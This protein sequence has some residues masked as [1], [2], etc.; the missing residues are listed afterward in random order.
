MEGLDSA[1]SRQK[2]TTESLNRAVEQFRVVAVAY[3]SGLD[4]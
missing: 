1:L 2:I 3:V 4:R